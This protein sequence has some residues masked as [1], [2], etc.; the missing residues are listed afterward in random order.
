MALSEDQVRI[1]P[2]VLDRLI[3]M[4]PRTTQDVPYSRSSSVRE[5]KAAVRRDLEWLL[6]TR[7]FNSAQEG[8]LEESKRSVAFYG[9]PDFTGMS[10][11]SPVQQKRITSLLEGALKIFEPRFMDIRVTMDPPTT[12]DRQMKFR[13][14]AQL[15]IE[16]APEP[17]T[18]DT[19]LQFGGDFSVVEK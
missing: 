10:V 9:I 4:D 7:C 13:I 19:V 16:P 6:N 15:D 5:L 17:V 2:S 3:D 11:N 18:F 8:D 1:T 12:F 14:A